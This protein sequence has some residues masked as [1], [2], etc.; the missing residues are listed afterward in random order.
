MIFRPYQ[1]KG[2]ADIRALFIQGK[3]RVCYAAPTGSGRTVLFCHAAKKAIKTR[4]TRRRSRASARTGRANLQ[5]VGG[6]RHSLRHHRGRISRKSRCPN[7][8]GH[9]AGRGAP[10]RS[11]A[12]YHALHHR[13][14]PSH[15]QPRPGYRSLT[16]R[17]ELGCSGQPPPLQRLDG[18]G[19]IGVFDGLVVGPTVKELI[20]GGWLSPFVVYAPET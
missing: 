20:A 7:A 17:R 11:T 3:Q 8:G 12:R 16:R 6:R 13:Q 4:S 15:P 5:G 19:L 10:A 14:V 2:I 9:G 18:K 1:E